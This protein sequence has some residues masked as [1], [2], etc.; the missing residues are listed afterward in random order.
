M[1]TKPGLAACLAVLA[2]LALSVLPT[3]P[4]LEATYVPTILKS[5]QR[6]TITI[7]NGSTSNTA[8]ITSVS[9]ANAVVHLMGYSGNDTSNAVADF[10]RVDLTNA[11]TV[12]ARRDSGTTG[13]ATAAYEVIEF[14]ASFVKSVQTGTIAFTDGGALTNTATITGVTTAKTLLFHTGQGVTGGTTSGGATSSIETRLDLTNAT[15]VTATR[16]TVAGTGATV[17]FT[18]VELR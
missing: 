15:T 1:T 5:V 18:A 3:P 12:T 6:G 9:T 14:V 4:A 13:S 8:T 16:N 10:V 11:T 2:V 7:T 17:G